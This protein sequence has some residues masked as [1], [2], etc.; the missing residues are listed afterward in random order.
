MLVGPP[1]LPRLT[2]EQRTAFV[3]ALA[4]A[5]LRQALCEDARDV[6]GAQPVTRHET[7]YE[8]RHGHDD[9]VGGE[10]EAR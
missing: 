8:C 1:A 5:A 2:P 4:S 6:R 7:G 10:R 9:S 3:R